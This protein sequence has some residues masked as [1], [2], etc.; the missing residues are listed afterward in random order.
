ML[1]ESEKP[2]GWIQNVWK[3]CPN[4]VL[5]E[6]EN[7]AGA[8]KKNMITVCEQ[9]GSWTWKPGGWIQNVWKLCLSN[10]VAEL[11]NPVVIFEIFGNLYPNNVVVESENPVIAKSENLVISVSEQCDS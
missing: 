1:A 10:V 4:N 6:P 8:L 5:A 7:L 9:C 2:G 11:E 3:L